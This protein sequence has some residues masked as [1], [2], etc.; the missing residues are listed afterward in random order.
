[1][2][3]VG[4]FGKGK[5]A[6]FSSD[7]APHWGCLLYTSDAA[8]EEDSVDFGGRRVIKKKEHCQ[9]TAVLR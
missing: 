8:D 1:M 3:A 9:Q 5:S 4:E 7:C 6:I 2:V